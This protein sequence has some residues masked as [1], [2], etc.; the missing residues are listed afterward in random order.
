[1]VKY[2]REEKKF[3]DD[4]MSKCFD[5]N[6]ITCHHGCGCREEALRRLSRTVVMVKKFI[7]RYKCGYDKLASLD[8]E[9]DLSLIKENNK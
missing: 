6:H 5:A 4:L 9:I 8:R 3:M 7:A 1:M 2:T